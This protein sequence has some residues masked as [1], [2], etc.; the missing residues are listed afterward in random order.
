MKIL[1]IDH[2]EN[3]ANLLKSRLEA[4]GGQ[5][6]I[7]AGK[8][9]ALDA[10]EAKPIDMV[11]IDPAP[12]NNARQ[13][14]ISLRRRIPT[15]TY[16][17]LMGIDVLPETGLTSGANDILN[18]PFAPDHIAKRVENA[19]RLLDTQRRLNDP[20]EDFPSGGGII[21]KSAYCQLFLSAI[22]RAD[23]YAERTYMMLISLRNYNQIKV[24]DGDYAAD[25]VAATMAQQIVR[26]RRQS[27]ILGQTAKYE[28][29]LLLQ[30]PAYEAEPNDATL[31]FA[32]TLANSDELARLTKV[33]IDIL[34]TLLEV[35][36]GYSPSTHEITVKSGA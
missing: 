30:R 5:V 35:P 16:V 28:Y 33:P 12:L 10:V 15:H 25:V 24:Q 17:V 1:V 21:A 13:L 3:T 8:S 2:D 31:R 4:L 23:R 14:I 34:I 26:I 22:D 7:V 9:D 6:T 20:R 36:S 19:Q 11:F 27:D 18:K 29:A 32:D